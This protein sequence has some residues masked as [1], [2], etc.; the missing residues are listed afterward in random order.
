MH[1]ASDRAAGVVA[2]PIVKCVLY[3]PL[4]GIT[5]HENIFSR[6]YSAAIEKVGIRQPVFRTISGVRSVILNQLGGGFFD[7][8]RILVNDRDSMLHLLE[9]PFARID[10]AYI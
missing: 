5:E 2:G 6:S 7:Q 10:A 3:R 1:E 8:R 9:L 4:A